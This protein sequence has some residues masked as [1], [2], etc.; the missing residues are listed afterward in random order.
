[1]EEGDENEAGE[2]DGS[3]SGEQTETHG[4]VDLNATWQDQ[5]NRA[6]PDKLEEHRTEKEK[7]TRHPQEDRTK[8]DGLAEQRAEEEVEKAG[9]ANFYCTKLLSGGRGLRQSRSKSGFVDDSLKLSSTNLVQKYSAPN[10]T[11]TSSSPSPDLRAT[12]H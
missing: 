12:Q 7:P 10:S 9:E 5:D 4:V 1:M 3:E 11:N 6:K 8:P 2:E